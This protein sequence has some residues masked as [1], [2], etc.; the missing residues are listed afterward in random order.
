MATIS[1][2]NLIAKYTTADILREAG[3]R[4]TL[5]NNDAIS[6]LKLI[7]KIRNSPDNNTG[8]MDIVLMVVFWGK[9]KKQNPSHTAAFRRMNDTIDLLRRTAAI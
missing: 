1:L 9:G 5:F 4:Y 6:L 7:G 8:G 3:K 2:K